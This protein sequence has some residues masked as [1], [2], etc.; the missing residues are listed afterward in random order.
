MV[1]QA[2]DPSHPIIKYVIDN[3]FTAFVKD[4]VEERQVFKYPPFVKMV[5]IVIKSRDFREGEKAALLLGD[6]LKKSF[7]SRVLGPQVP[8]V[9]RIKN[10]Y[11]QQ[12]LIKI[13]R[14]AS[15]KKARQI[16]RKNLDFT[17]QLE[18]FKRVRVNVDVDPY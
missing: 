16:L 7:G 8:L 12:I 1:I 4:Q 6:Y 3:N 13:E 5:R 14:E 18:D 17:S 2:S 11:L 10:Q 9:G 15:F